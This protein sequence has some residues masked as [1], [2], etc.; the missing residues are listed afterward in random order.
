VNT[1]DMSPIRRIDRK[2]GARVQAQALDAWREAE[3]QVQARWDAYLA[4]DR[5]SARAACAGY[6]EVL[7]AEAATAAALAEAF[8]P[9]AAA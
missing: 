9:A 1:I 8:N 7:D 6:L 4:A 3:L 5:G 2:Y